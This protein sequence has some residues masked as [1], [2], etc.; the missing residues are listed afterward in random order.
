[1]LQGELDQMIPVRVV[2]H[3]RASEVMRSV[4]VMLDQMAPAQGQ[5]QLA[6]EAALE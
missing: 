4:Q 6:A 2:L 3:Q 5:H 1:M